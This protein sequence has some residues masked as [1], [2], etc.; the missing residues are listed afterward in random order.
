MLS[1]VEGLVRELRTIGIPVSTT[2]HIDAAK[3]LKVIDIGNRAEV[4]AAL[5]ATMVKR[6]E[7]MKAFD[8]VF[9]LFFSGMQAFDVEFQQSEG[10]TTVAE[11]LMELEDDALHEMLVEAL[12]EDDELMVNA[13]VEVFV[14][15]KANVQQGAQ[16]AVHAHGVH[17]DKRH[18]VFF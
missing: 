5:C 7:H 2:E 14:S 8:T 10:G 12:A 9:D 13:L 18:A 17:E 16:V 6:I 4:K 15:R 3:A 11:M 1:T